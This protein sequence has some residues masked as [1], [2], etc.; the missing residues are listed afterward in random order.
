G[1]AIGGIESARL[2]AQGRE[3][4]L[5]TQLDHQLDALAVPPPAGDAIRL[6]AAAATADTIVTRLRARMDAATIGSLT[7]GTMLDA[8]TVP[9]APS[10]PFV[11]LDLFLAALAGLL[12]G[13]VAAVLLDLRP[14]TLATPDDVDRLLRL[15][16]VGVVPDFARVAHA[17]V[18]ADVYRA[19]R[20]SVLFADPARPPRTLLVTSAAAGDGKTATVVNLGLS[21]AAAGLRVALVD[22]AIA[23]PALARGL[24]L[25]AGATLADVL[26]GATPLDDAL[27]AVPAAGGVLRVL[28]GGT[29]AE[30]L[31]TPRAGKV[32]RQL[33]DRHD[34]VLIDSTAS[35]PLLAALADGVLVVVPAD[36]PRAA[37]RGVVER[38]RAA[39]CRLVGG[40]LNRVDPDADYYRAYA[41]PFPASSAARREA[42]SVGPGDERALERRRLLRDQPPDG[43]P[44]A[45]A[46]GEVDDGPV[47]VHPHVDQA[48]RHL[49]VLDRRE[50]LPEHRDLVLGRHLAEPAER[51]HVV[52]L[53]GRDVAIE[54]GLHRLRARRDGWR[55]RR[56]GRRRDGPRNARVPLGGRGRL[57]RR[58]RS[59]LGLRDGRRAGGR[60][61]LGRLRLRGRRGGRLGCRRDVD[62]PLVRDVRAEVARHGDAHR[63]APGFAVGTTTV[64]PVPTG[65]PSTVHV[66]ASRSPA[67]AGR[68]VTA[69]E[70]SV[71]AWTSTRAAPG[72]DATMRGGRAGRTR[73]VQLRSATPPVPMAATVTWRRP[74]SVGVGAY[75]QRAPLPADCSSTVQRYCTSSPLA[76][77][78]NSS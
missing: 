36:A 15:P 13:A 33:A 16:T 48:H 62:P 64:A 30:L 25:A 46:L 2:D 9:T 44:E 65:R 43:I 53:P 26:R 41:Y 69:S 24:G 72:T 29:T 8:A 77:A 23:N 14:R 50:V 74:A 6:E 39:R 40:V 19:V 21:L 3:A 31:A 12:A 22:A 58:R 68:A 4:A 59:R 10:E 32:L 51:V 56:R 34:V 35:G 61:R 67:V 55:R 49:E 52:R 73:T 7:D 38:V 37:A 42:E 78:A 47:S 71:P 1:R 57:G 60:R 5:R 54:K 75:V 70:T 28:P 63:S 17:G 76:S 27:R 18:A 11:A 66:Y 20:V 45:I